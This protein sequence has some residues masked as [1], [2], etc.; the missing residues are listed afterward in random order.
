MGTDLATPQGASQSKLTCPACGHKDRFIEVMES[1]AH[2]VNGNRDYIKLI[3]GVVD[4]YICS[5][6]GISFD[7]DW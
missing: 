6:C 2:W 7:I 1:E 3:E 4:H 5:A